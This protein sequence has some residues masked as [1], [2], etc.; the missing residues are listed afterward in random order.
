M[1]YS[2]SNHFECF[3]LRVVICSVGMQITLRCF[4][5][6]QDNSVS[7]IVSPGDCV[8]SSVYTICAQKY[9]TNIFRK[10]SP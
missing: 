9:Y 1:Y 3:S 7:S 6:G 8:R 10:C 4:V 2:L 5:N